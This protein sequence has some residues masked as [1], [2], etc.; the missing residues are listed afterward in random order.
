MKV[1]DFLGRGWKFPISACKESVCM[2]EGED[3]IKESI[4]LILNT[5][6]GERVMRPEFGCRINEMVFASNDVGTATLIEG[7][8]EE[9]LLNW[10]PRI[11]IYSITATPRDNEQVLDISIEYIVKSSNSK[12]N[13]V[14][15]FYLESVAK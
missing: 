14:Y 8:V 2:S 13:L 12:Q 4:I 10:E 6:R 15:P 11:E 1:I 3:S 5:V 7:Y 9:A